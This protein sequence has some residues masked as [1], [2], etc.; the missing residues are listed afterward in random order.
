MIQRE[1][2]LYYILVILITGFTAWALTRLNKLVFRKIRRR[3]ASLHMVFLE[4]INTIILV[5]VSS[6]VGLSFLGGLDSVWKS[7]LGGTAVV[8]AVIVIAAQDVIRDILAGLM[9]SA[10]KPFDIGNRIEL[11]GGTFGIIKDITMRHVVIHTW[12]SQEMIIPNSRLNTMIVL[13]DSYHTGIRSYQTDYHIGYGSDVRKAMEII[14]QA[15]MDSPYTVAGKKTDAGDVYDEVYFMSYEASSLR[16]S[17]T[18][19]YMDTPT[20]VVKSDVNT[21]VNEALKAGGIEIPYN[22]VNV[23]QKT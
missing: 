1:T 4:K 18:V 7:V 9:I 23:V 17:T 12:G 15:V 13:N 3:G 20:E 10:Y 19:Y 21:G 5:F 16:M 22:Y 2:L 14:K 11:E 8:S 6:I